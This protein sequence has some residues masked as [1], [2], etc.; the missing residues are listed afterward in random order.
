MIKKKQLIGII[1]ALIIAGIIIA[2]TFE[3]GS[4][5]TVATTKKVK[6]ETATTATMT[7]DADMDL[8][9]DKT[10]TKK[11]EESV[12]EEIQKE[13]EVKV[14]TQNTED[15]TI[16]TSSILEK[17]VTQYV[18]VGSLNMRSG[19]GTNYPVVIAVTQGQALI[20]S[21]VT[22]SWSKVKMNDKTGWVYSEYLSDTKPIVEKSVVG[23]TPAP[24]T[25]T[26]TKP[27]KSGN[28]A[29]TLKTVNGNHQLILVTT[30]GYNTNHATIQAFE[31]DANGKWNPIL[32]TTGYI[33]KNG[34][35]SNKK[36]GDGKSPVGKYTIGTAFG[37]KGNPGTKLPFR[38]IT[39]DDVWV[40]DPESPLYN[41]WQSRNETQGQWK[42]AENMMHRLYTYGFVINYNTERTPYKGSAIFFHV[43]SGYTL[44]CTA[45]S[46]ANVIKLLKWLDP[47][48]NPVILQTP[49]QELNKY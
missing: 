24:S 28:I 9:D 2:I 30:D 40:D 32:N 26:G 43:G 47:A 22:D 21:E 23:A 36:E 48:K 42:S 20:V 33:G 8:K 34:F 49:V 38:N 3:I 46:E 25:T 5:D 6:E 17:P 15:E 12:N 45:T 14:D 19:A 37:Q 16:V 10:V 41:S 35:A 44:G 27:E 18:N 4:N 39:N 1:T 11:S 31:K 7:I 29:D 13:N